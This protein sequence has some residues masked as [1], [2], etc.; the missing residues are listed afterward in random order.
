MSMVSPVLEDHSS[1]NI[2][3]ATRSLVIPR[4]VIHGINT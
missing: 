1:L 4:L 2:I 3:R